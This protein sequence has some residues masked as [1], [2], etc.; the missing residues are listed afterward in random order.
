MASK[1]KIVRAS[2]SDLEDILELQKICFL[3]EA[4]LYN[5]YT[6]HPMIQPLESLKLEF[7]KGIFL[8]AV[9]KGQL[10]GSVRGF[11]DFETGYIYKHF[12][13]PW[14]QNKGIGKLLMDS[15]EEALLPCR[16]YELFTGYKSNK[17]QYIYRKLG[18]SEFKRIPFSKELTMIFM[19]KTLPQSA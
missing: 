16:R 6:M 4:E 5:D 18:Y 8:K 17:S 1:V 15:I 10:A 13:S 2:I 12:V 3:P 11:N 7:E 19:E 14:H 9:V